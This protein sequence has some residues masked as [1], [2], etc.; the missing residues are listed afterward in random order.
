MFIH[1]CVLVYQHRSGSTRIVLE[2]N[3][4]FYSLLSHANKLGYSCIFPLQSSLFVIITV[5]ST[6]P[7]LPPIT[8][9]L[10]F[11]GL[12]QPTVF[13]SSLISPIFSSSFLLPIRIDLDLFSLVYPAYSLSINFPL[14]VHCYFYPILVTPLNTSTLVFSFW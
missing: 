9:I 4:S 1:V 3:Q 10:F 6:R 8:P 7:H 12:P 13:P 14:F 5:R 11:F 2:L